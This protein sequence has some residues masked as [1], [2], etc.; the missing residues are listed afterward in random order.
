MHARGGIAEMELTLHGP[1]ATPT[2]V[3][4]SLEVAA[5]HALASHPHFRSR[6]ASRRLARR[7]GA[8][9]DLLPEA[10]RPE[11]SREGRLYTADR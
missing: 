3:D 2:C 4:Q 11:R 10:A 1:L 8:S 9:A 6:V 7:R 5:R